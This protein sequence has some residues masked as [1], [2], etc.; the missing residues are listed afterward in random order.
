MTFS[1]AS[2]DNIV[3]V[4]LQKNLEGYEKHISFFSGEL[5]DAEVK[6]VMEKHAYALVKEL[7]FF[8]IYILHSKI[9]TYV[10]SSSI[11]YI[12]MQPNSEGKRG[13]WITKI[14]EYD[15]EIKPTKLIKGQGL[16]WL[17]A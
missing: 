8:W 9:I 15:L 14:L 12:L 1:F 7:V 6:Y 11:K 2:E 4:F 3:V 17:L 13:K 16:A 10:P 5:R